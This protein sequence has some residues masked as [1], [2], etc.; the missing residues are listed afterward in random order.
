MSLRAVMPS[1]A[2]PTLIIFAKAPQPGRVKTRLA[3]SLGEEGAARLHARLIERTLG[4]ALEAG[5]RRVELH[6]APRVRHPLFSR[7]AER[8]HV[9]LRG[10]RGADLGARMLRACAGALR[11]SRAVVLIG[12]DCPELRPADL[13]AAARALRGGAHAVFAPAEDGGYALIGL[14]RASPRLFAGIGWGGPGVMD[15]TRK[16]IAELGWRS[17]ELRTVWD[18]DRPADYVRFTR[19]RKFSAPRPRARRSGDSRARSGG[20]G[21]T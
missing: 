19:L 13:R 10:Q 6:C 15:E 7:L 16:R 11:T 20:S 21:R 12:A 3:P 9:S 17:R 1:A 18:V 4:M 5:F 2:E 14:R 8:F